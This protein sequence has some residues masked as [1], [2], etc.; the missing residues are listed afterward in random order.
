MVLDFILGAVL[1]LVFGYLIIKAINCLEILFGIDIMF[2]IVFAIIVSPIFI[3]LS[4]IMGNY[5][6]RL[7]K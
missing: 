6:W 3:A 4:L 2:Y 5:V 7:I 1:V